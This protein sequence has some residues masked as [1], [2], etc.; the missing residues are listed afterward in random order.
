[1]KSGIVTMSA[2]SAMPCFRFVSSKF[3][4]A[5]SRQLNFEVKAVPDNQV[6]LIQ[7]PPFFKT[8]FKNLFVRSALEHSVA[9]I[10]VMDPEKI[11]AHTIDRFHRAKVLVIILV[12]LARAAESC[13]ASAGNTSCPLSFHSGW[14]G[15]SSFQSNRRG[16]MCAQLPRLVRLVRAV[17]CQG[18]DVRPFRVVVE[19]MKTP[20]FIEAP[21]SVEGV[22]VTCIAR[23]KLARLQI[24]APQVCIAK[25]LRVLAGKKMKAQPAAIGA[26]N[27]LGFS[28]ES[29][30]Q[31][32]NKISIDL[33]L[34]LQIARKIF[35]SDL[36]SSA[37]E[38]K[39][40]MQRMIKFFHEHDQRPDIAIAHSCAGIV[41]FELFNKPARV[42]NADIKLATRA[43]QKRA[44]EL[45]Q[46]APGFSSEDRQLRATRPIDQT[47]FQIDPN[48]RVGS[49]K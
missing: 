40:S 24:T 25:C 11:T 8:P 19:R 48:L 4:V 31:K 43:A 16:A 21:R 1:M 3:G 47:I 42:V 36:A 35:R 30:K 28:K 34:E 7:A 12:Q 33:G 41:L 9:K 15:K 23:G 22:E 49:L 46:F 18:Q 2:R 10:S 44:R 45:A 20:D 37:F 29:N 6:A 13:P 27:S 5:K 17:I 38:L 32:K 14:S 26:R 39:R